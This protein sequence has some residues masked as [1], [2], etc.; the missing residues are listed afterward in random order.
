MAVARV[1]NHLGASTPRRREAA[2]SLARSLVVVRTWVST[3]PEPS[4]PDAPL[5]GRVLRAL[6]GRSGG[7]GTTHRSINK[8]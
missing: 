7:G 2:T 5:R 6:H 3:C 1:Y 8:A 4:G